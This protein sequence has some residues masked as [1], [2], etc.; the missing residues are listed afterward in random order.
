MYTIEEFR[1]KFGPATFAS[2]MR[3]IRLRD[4]LTQNEMA[5]K[6]KISVSHLSDIENERKYVSVAR[7]AEFARRMK[8]PMQLYVALALRDQV[9]LAGLDFNVQIS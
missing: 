1:A 9:R 3:S 6:L 5:K 7:A 2:L 4:D 8:E